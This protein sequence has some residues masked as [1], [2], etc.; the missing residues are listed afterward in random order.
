MEMLG[1]VMLIA[2]P[3]DAYREIRRCY[4]RTGERCLALSAQ[5][6]LLEPL[7]TFGPSS[8]VLLAT[9]AAYREANEYAITHGYCHERDLN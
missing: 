6:K 1:E 3:L 5:G 8:Y 4:D 9:E 7:P 2:A